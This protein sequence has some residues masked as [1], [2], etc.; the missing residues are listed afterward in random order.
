[1]PHLFSPP[2]LPI[3]WHKLNTAGRIDI[4]FAL[5]GKLIHTTETNTTISINSEQKL[6][7][8]N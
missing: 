2:K 7:E 6:L 5:D 1:M 3:K 8:T 4:S